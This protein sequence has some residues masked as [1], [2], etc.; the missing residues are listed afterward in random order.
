[1]TNPIITLLDNKKLI[2]HNLK[3]EKSNLNPNTMIENVHFMLT[4]DYH[5]VLI[6]N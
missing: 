5:L 3:K 6:A 4:K 2:E 1:M